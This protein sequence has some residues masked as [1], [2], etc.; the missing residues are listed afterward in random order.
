MSERGSFTTQYIYC[1][2]CYEAVRE[3]LVSDDKYLRGV[4]IPMWGEGQ[5]TGVG[6]GDDNHPRELPIVAGK[7]GG[8]YAGEEKYAML[9]L[10]AEIKP[11]LCPG[12]SII[13]GVIPDSSEP[14]FYNTDNLDGY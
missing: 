6:F 1:D 14:V 11:N 3:V 10:L 2:R 4:P 8:L 5:R 13:V 7:I 12:H 9:E